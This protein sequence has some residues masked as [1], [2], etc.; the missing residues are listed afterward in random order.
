MS[1]IDSVESARYSEQHS[2]MSAGRGR[3][4]GEWSSS[5]ESLS[6]YGY[7]TRPIAADKI[8]SYGT[9]VPLLTNYFRLGKLPDFQFLQYH[10]S[11]EPQIDCMKRLNG[12]VA[13]QR[14]TFGGKKFKSSRCF[15]N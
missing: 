8:G 3:G 15:H 6:D 5:Q 9:R 4:R 1:S 13:Q 14:D 2:R 7:L 12:L 10:V 11:F